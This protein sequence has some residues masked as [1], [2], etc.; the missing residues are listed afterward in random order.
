MRLDRIARELVKAYLFGTGFASDVPGGSL[1]FCKTDAER[2]AARHPISVQCRLDAGET[3]SAAVPAELMPTIHSAAGSH[4]LRPQSRGRVKLASADPRAPPRIM[5]NFLSA[6]DDL[7]V[8][9]D[10]MRMAR[11][12]GRQAPLQPFVGA[13]AARR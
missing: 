9:R 7:K 12:V 2:E 1:P 11:E 10:G 3:L 4:C 6:E 13:E 5:Q 8:L